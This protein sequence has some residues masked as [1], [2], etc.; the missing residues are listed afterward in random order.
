MS[1]GKVVAAKPGRKDAARLYI[2]I[3]NGRVFRWPGRLTPAHQQ[4]LIARIDANGGMVK[5]KNWEP[6]DQ[7]AFFR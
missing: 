7:P 1:M 3:K 2:K 4:Q 5:L 6:C